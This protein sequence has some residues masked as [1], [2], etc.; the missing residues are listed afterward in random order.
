[1]PPAMH[2]LSKDDDV[3]N[4]LGTTTTYGLETRTA[5]GDTR[6]PVFHARVTR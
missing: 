2:R 4:L 6:D 1:M 5:V 3:N